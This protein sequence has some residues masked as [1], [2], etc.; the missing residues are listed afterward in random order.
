MGIGFQVKQMIMQETGSYNDLGYRPYTSSL[1]DNTLSVMQQITGGGD[2]VTAEALMGVAGQ[3]LRPAAAPVGVA[4]IQ[5]GWATRRFRF[6]LRVEL[7]NRFSAA[8]S[9]EAVIS[10]YTD[11]TGASATSLAIDE[12]MRLY[13]N[14]IVLLNATNGFDPTIGQTQ[15]IRMI[16]NAQ[17]IAGEHTPV[18]VNNQLQSVGAVSM[19]PEDVYQEMRSTFYTGARVIND[20]A[21]FSAGIKASNRANNDPARYLS[22]ILSAHN[23]VL[24]SQNEDKYHENLRQAQGM[25]RENPLSNNMFI[26]NLQRETEIMRTGSV[27]W[28][29]LLQL[30]EHLDRVT[31]I[32]FL[33]SEAYAMSNY[34]Q[35]SDRMMGAS[36][37]Q[38][39]ATMIANAIP[40][41]MMGCMM[42]SCAFVATNRSLTGDVK[43]EMAGVGSF[44]DGMDLSGEIQRFKHETA[45]FIDRELTMGRSRLIDLTVR[46]NAIG[47]T[48]VTISIDGYP[49]TTYVI[50]S[51]SDA[52]IAPVVTHGIDALKRVSADI[53]NIANNLSVVSGVENG[54]NS[55]I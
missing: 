15:F 53:N 47:D 18:V 48:S 52:V 39:T 35:N 42:V 28:G 10:G 51:F 23:T 44:V 6:L 11:Y 30:N 25:V 17:I 55:F 16:D 24:G 34:V 45:L 19:R 40:G 49:A 14:N 43:V 5:N 1:Q 12:N 32:N 13:F 29:E 4:L 8:G 27:T 41:I 33:N 7:Q 3:I 2:N 54:Y 37:E 22:K 46:A 31:R 9:Q 21:T 36:P 50:P 26:H 38:V 20:S